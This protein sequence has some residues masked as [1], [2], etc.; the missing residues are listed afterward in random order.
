MLD[1]H[2]GRP[3]WAKLHDKSAHE[4]RQLYPRFDD[5]VALRQKVDPCGV[6]L[7]RY[8]ANLLGVG[9]E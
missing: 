6:L 7:N 9:Y 4:L 5:F 8:L 2:G 1:R 3:H